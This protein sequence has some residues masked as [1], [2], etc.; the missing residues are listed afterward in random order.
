M[1]LPQPRQNEKYVVVIMFYSAED[2]DISQSSLT[3]YLIQAFEKISGKSKHRHV[4][5]SFGVINYK[6]IRLFEYDFS[7]WN[8]RNSGATSISKYSKDDKD[9][10]MLICASDAIYFELNHHTYNNLINNLIVVQR[11][12]DSNIIPGLP[13]NNIEYP[14]LSMILSD[15][16]KSCCNIF[17]TT[18]EWKLKDI[19]LCMDN[20][21]KISQC[22]QYVLGLIIYC[23]R[24]NAITVSA[25]QK[26]EIFSL[27]FDKTALHPHVLF[28]ILKKTGRC[29]VLLDKS[30]K[31]LLCGE[32]LDLGKIR[33]KTPEKLEFVSTT[34]MLDFFE[35]CEA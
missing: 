22:S 16:C 33:L 11:R 21:I 28:N 15:Y 9:G 32:K 6:T 13:I 7:C 35:S 14:S 10:H 25:K 4:G 24:H 2:I 23:I 3:A 19:D 30:R 5:L 17:M 8:G 18:S 29:F 26:N 27:L 34:H 1:I 31:L 12:A 20:N